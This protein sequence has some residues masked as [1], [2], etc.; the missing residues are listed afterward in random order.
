MNQS[1]ATQRV[2]LPTAFEVSERVSGPARVLCLRG[3][4][5]IATAPT[6]RH[7]L[8]VAI[9]LRCD[10]VLD[11]S[12]CDFMDCQGLHT[13]LDVHGRLAKQRRCLLLA[14][15]PPVIRRLLA[16]TATDRTFARATTTQVALARL[17]DPDTTSRAASLC[18][19]AVA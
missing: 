2:S 17:H 1:H 12:E 5:D 8:A 10:I 18:L 3:E 14:G 15:V 6:L 13:L 16:A 4:L 7:R 11:L 19:R 9:R